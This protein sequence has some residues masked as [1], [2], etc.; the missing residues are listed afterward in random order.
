MAAIDD[1]SDCKDLEEFF[2]STGQCF[3]KVDKALNDNLMQC[4]LECLESRLEDH[5][6][7]VHAIAFAIQNTAKD[8]LKQLIEDL[9]SATQNVSE[10]IHTAKLQR[11]IMEEGRHLG[12]LV[13]K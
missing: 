5:F 13:Q 4:L 7:V 3:D 8:G 12:I 10:E 11:E 6:Q 9:L 1:D 2:A